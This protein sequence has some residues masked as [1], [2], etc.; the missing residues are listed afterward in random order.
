MTL[1]FCHDS[2][3]TH[4][5]SLWNSQN[6]CFERGSHHEDDQFTNLWNQQHMAAT[7]CFK[8]F[9]TPWV[10]LVF[11]HIAF[12]H[13]FQNFIYL[14]L[15]S[16]LLSGSSFLCLYLQLASLVS[17]VT[18]FVSSAAVWISLLN[19]VWMTLNL[20]SDLRPVWK[21]PLVYLVSYR[22]LP[23]L[24]PGNN[25]YQTGGR[26]GLL[27]GCSWR[28]AALAICHKM[29]IIIVPESDG[30][31]CCWVFVCSWRDRSPINY[32]F[33]FLK[34]SWWWTPQQA[35]T[36]TCVDAWCPPRVTKWLFNHR[37]DA[38]SLQGGFWRQQGFLLLSTLQLKLHF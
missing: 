20:S 12:I 18:T 37:C 22:I 25:N 33:Q 36:L 10:H 5:V 30:E 34:Q 24:L 32:P 7:L 4:A 23:A 29:K 35:S 38:I 19:L 2:V 27:M 28:F 21:L 16:L 6:I 3:S 15:T 8:L 31:I 17:A 1:S 14:Y 11:P 13:F 26:A 9:E